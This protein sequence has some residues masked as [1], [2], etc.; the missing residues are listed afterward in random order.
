MCE[1]LADKLDDVGRVMK[2]G[3]E[4]YQVPRSICLFFKAN[5]GRRMSFSLISTIQAKSV[6]LRLYQAA[7]NTLA[8]ERWLGL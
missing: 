1:S 2:H 6:C 4:D 7:E 5:Y 3:V 8:A